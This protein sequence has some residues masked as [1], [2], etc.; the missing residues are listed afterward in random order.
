MTK[1]VF[2]RWLI[3]TTLIG[4]CIHKLYRIY[5]IGYN[6]QRFKT[7]VSLALCQPANADLN[8]AAG[9]VFLSFFKN[10][11]I[12]Y[13]INWP[14]TQ[15]CLPWYDSKFR[16]AKG[17][18]KLVDRGALAPPGPP[19]EPPLFSMQILL[20]F[21]LA[22]KAIKYNFARSVFKQVGINLV[23]TWGGIIVCQQHHCRSLNT[24]PL[25]AGEAGVV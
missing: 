16:G 14:F 12:V 25:A 7:C 5:V 18:A 10:I 13:R 9:D 8:L 11:Y 19:L 15:N 2:H 24:L 3:W 1:Q 22:D 4:P 21:L 23:K 6:A 20:S 17:G